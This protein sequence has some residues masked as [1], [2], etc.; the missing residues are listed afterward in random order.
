MSGLRGCWLGLP[1][2][3]CGYFRI[4]QGPRRRQHSK[5]H[6]EPH[7]A[8]PQ[9]NSATHVA[10]PKSAVF[11]LLAFVVGSALLA[12][13][14]RLRCI[15]ELFILRH[16]VVHVDHAPFFGIS[17]REAVSILGLRVHE[18]GE[19]VPVIPRRLLETS[20]R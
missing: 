15:S 6:H 20:A 10:R 17:Q 16:W 3:G 2:C 11:Q 12:S 4:L 1:F 18:G 7:I 5:A 14:R 13:V 19:H 9:A 8:R